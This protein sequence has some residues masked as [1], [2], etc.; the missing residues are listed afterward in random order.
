MA[1]HVSNLN[2]G[3]LLVFRFKIKLILHDAQIALMF[4]K[5][6]SSIRRD[7]WSRPPVRVV[8]PFPAHS[9]VLPLR[10]VLCLQHSRLT[11]ESECGRS[12]EGSFH[13]SAVQFTALPQCAGERL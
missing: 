13:R 8:S 6:I 7:N 3:H 12:Q 4:Q 9:D 10:T 11:Q 5:E 2:E 1:S